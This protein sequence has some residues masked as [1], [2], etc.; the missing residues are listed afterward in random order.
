MEPMG[1]LLQA[2]ACVCRRPDP[3]P[4]VFERGVRCAHHRDLHGACWCSSGADAARWCGPKARER[5]SA[6][7]AA[8]VQD[9]AD[10]S[11]HVVW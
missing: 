5:V 9:T 7:G 4:N 1:Q 10:S 3:S 6:P 11:S 2:S 8:N